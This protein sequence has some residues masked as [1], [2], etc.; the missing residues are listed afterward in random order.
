[1]SHEH[2][3]D[4]DHD[5]VH[6]HGLHGHHHHHGSRSGNV[7]FAGILNIGFTII[8]L[9][10]GLLTNS[11][12]ILSDALHDLGDSI[13]LFTAYFAEKQAERPADKKRT[14][15]YA[16][17]SLFSAVFTAVV[18][19]VGSVFILI[20]AVQRLFAPEEVMATGMIGVAIFGV[21]VNSLAYF[22]LSHGHSANEKMLSWHMLED[23]LGWVAVL[24]AGI[25]IYFTDF[26]LVDPLLTIGYTV[27]ILWNVLRNLREVVNLLMQ[28]VPSNV[29]L[30]QVL[31][32]VTAVPEVQSVHDVHVWSLDGEHNIFTG[33]VVVTP[34]GMEQQS[35]VR[36][37][38]ANI[39]R[40]YHVGHATI[41][42]EVAGQCS[43]DDCG[44]ER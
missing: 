15:G 39:L 35:S 24:V 42:I 28:G 11:V 18:L 21:L 9:I 33:H 37:A 12:A 26:Y 1:M 44:V 5:H 23:V 25:V 14:F 43:G 36:E 10:G 7:L 41:E 40:E 29:P 2:H 16:R 6:H 3:H 34:A 30:E 22:R 19:L 32:R 38:V 13:S 27:F 17:L 20:E 8:E 31:E 4:H